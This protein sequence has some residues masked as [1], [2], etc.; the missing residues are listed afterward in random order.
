METSKSKPQ[1]LT[2]AKKPT[3]TKTSAG[4][5]KGSALSRW[6]HL[7]LSMLSFVIVLFFAVTG[8]TLN[9][10]SWFEQ[11]ITHEIAGK[12]AISWL[13]QASVEGVDKLVVAEQLRQAN[14]LRGAVTDFRIDEEEC[15]VSFRGPGYTADATIDR[16]TGN[17]QI[18]ETK[19]G[20]IALLNDLHKGRDTGS[21]WSLAIDGA[22]LFMVL[23]SVTGLWLL[24]YL[25]R[26]RWSGWMWLLIGGLIMLGVYVWAV[27]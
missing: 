7:Y 4:N 20:M 18:T 27:P 9:H 24:Y 23:V 22:A 8:F 6:L 25:K 14:S 26:R 16:T 5:R 10:A 15:Y 21:A 2:T 1:R 12:L 13:N 11:S 19:M 3:E 17:Y